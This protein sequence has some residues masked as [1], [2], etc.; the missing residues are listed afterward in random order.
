MQQRLGHLFTQRLRPIDGRTSFGV[1]QAPA[2]DVAHHAQIDD[3]AVQ[4][5][6]VDVAQGGQRLVVGGWRAQKNILAKG[7]ASVSVTPQGPWPG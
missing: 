6:I 7:S 1:Q 3:A 4:L 5:R 2:L